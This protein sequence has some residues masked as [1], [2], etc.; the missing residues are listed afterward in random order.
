VTTP[1]SSSKCLEDGCNEGEKKKITRD[2]HTNT[3]G[4]SIQCKL[5][6][7]YC[8]AQPTDL[9]STL[10][11]VRRI[12]NTAKL[13][14]IRHTWLL[15]FT[16]ACHLVPAWLTLLKLNVNELWAMWLILWLSFIQTFF[17]VIR[18]QLLYGL[19]A[20]CSQTMWFIYSST[21]EVGIIVWN[22]INYDNAFLVYEVFEKT[23]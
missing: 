7:D 1:R 11:N 8:W 13:S 4:E 22:C 2:T 18:F 10:C 9:N 3:G 15:I 16:S 14:R 19:K 20:Q 12:I 21:L 6:A 5:C 23:A 17:K